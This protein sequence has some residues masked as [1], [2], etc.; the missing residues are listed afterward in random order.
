ME[1]EQ[2][3]EFEKYAVSSDEIVNY[4]TEYGQL[5]M[6]RMI[7]EVK[8]IKH[9]K[10]HVETF[11]KLPE[12]KIWTAGEDCIIEFSRVTKRKD[13]REYL[14]EYDPIFGFCSRHE[15]NP[16]YG[17]RHYVVHFKHKVKK[18]RTVSVEYNIWKYID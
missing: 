4:D 13:R 5:V 12:Q 15:K 14:V 9:I 8:I 10:Q 7:D 3:L 17:K 2:K 11:G 18:F 1:L 16:N 6:K